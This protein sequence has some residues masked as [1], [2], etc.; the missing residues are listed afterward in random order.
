M[1]PCTGGY[2]RV[3]GYAACAGR[4]CFP[5]EEGGYVRTESEYPCACV[6]D[7][8]YGFP[9]P[10]PDG[11]YGFRAGCVGGAEGASGYVVVVVDRG[12]PSPYPRPPSYDPRT[13]LYPRLSGY[14]YGTGG[15]E[16]VGTYRGCPRCE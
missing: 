2:G 16:L 10:D 5:S 6:C 8:G 11:G 4:L 9:L 13:S 14:G 7:V 3:S 12:A 15:D 1:L